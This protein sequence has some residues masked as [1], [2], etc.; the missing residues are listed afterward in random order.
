MTTTFFDKRYH[1]PGTSPGTLIAAPEGEQISIRL[2]DYSSTDYTAKDLVTVDECKPFLEQKTITWIHIQGQPS[3]DT[4]NYLGESLNLHPLTLED[5][6]NTGQRPKVDDYNGQIFIILSLPIITN[7]HVSIEQISLFAGPDY[8]ISFHNGKRDAFSTVRKRLQNHLGKIRDRGAD[9]LVYALLDTVIDEGFPVLESFGEEIEA[10]EEELLQSPD[11]NTLKKLHD[12][13]RELLLIRRMLWPQREILN[14]LIR[15]EIL[16]FKD[17][18]R[19]YLR[20]CYDHTI[21]ILDLIETYRDMTASMLDVYLSSISYRLNDVMRILTVIATIFIP[22]TF[23]VGVYGMNFG[24]NDK[25]PWAMPELGWYYAY[26]VLWI[27]M[28]LMAVGML[29]FFR[30]RGWF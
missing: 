20:D 21:Q 24:I 8:V 3:I 27:I 29:L 2:V 15:D 1:P 23:L 16:L 6:H 30:R 5:V 14:V 22:L 26:P 25:S 10:L 18:T 17:E 19:I 12:I 11:R 9:Y 4:L 13:K 28:I 7:G